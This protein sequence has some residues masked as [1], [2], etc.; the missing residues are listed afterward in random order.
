MNI[1]RLSYYEALI[2][3]WKSTSKSTAQQV[4]DTLIQVDEPKYLSYGGIN[5]EKQDH[6][7]PTSKK[8]EINPRK[9]DINKPQ[10]WFDHDGIW[11]YN[12]LGALEEASEVAK[13]R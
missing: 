3:K 13:N 8:V 1:L 7:K 12:Y 10:A 11:I 5:M 4:A 6:G 9:E 2:G